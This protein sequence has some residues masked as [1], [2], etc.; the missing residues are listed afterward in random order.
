MVMDLGWWLLSLFAF[1]RLQELCSVNT[2]VPTS[3]WRQI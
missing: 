1:L 2:M 3:R